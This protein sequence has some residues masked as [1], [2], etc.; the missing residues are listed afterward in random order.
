LEGEADY[1]LGQEPVGGAYPSS[2]WQAG[3]VVRQQ[4][5][6]QIP[7]ALPGR[8]EVG[9]FVTRN[10]KPVPWSRGWIPLGSDLLLGPV[11]IE[12]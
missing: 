11:W 7:D 9:M 8:Y 5:G 12:P 4:P 10:G 1:P 2:G 3:Q 6:L